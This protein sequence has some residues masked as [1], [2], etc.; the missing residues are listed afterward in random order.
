MN[1]TTNTDTFRDGCSTV[2][3]RATL[4]AEFSIGDLSMVAIEVSDGSVEI[5]CVDP[6]DGIEMFQGYVS[7][8]CL[9][10]STRRRALLELN[11]IRTQYLLFPRKVA[12]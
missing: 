12:V 8:P 2:A 11:D 10:L 6:A 5:Y 9:P 3:V 1:N 4:R 7:D